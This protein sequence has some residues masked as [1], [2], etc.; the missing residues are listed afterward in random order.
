MYKSEVLF[1]AKRK[2][3]IIGSGDV[4]KT[5]AA[6]FYAKGYPVMIGSRTPQKLEEWKR[7][8]K[9]EVQTGTFSQTAEFG[10]LIV[11]AVKGE[12]AL[13]VL[14][15]IGNDALQDKTVLD[16]T[17]PI[18]RKEAEDG[19]LSF[20]TTLDESLMERLQKQ[21]PRAR[22]V[23]AW[24]CVG[25]AAMVDPV[26]MG[27]PPTMFICGNSEQAKEEAV[28]ILKEF[29]WSVA[30]MG[31][32]RAARAIEPLCILWCIPGLRENDWNHAFR[33]LRAK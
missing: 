7:S 5:L 4:G 1:M 10:E 14:T 22:F 32:A 17:N 16:T 3:G 6:G 28:E 20:F 30:D 26:F 8:K 12:S 29:G 9:I 19:V 2:I 25:N 18:A 21:V 23:K 13:H 11:F 31:T 33:L 24:S 15:S 27:G